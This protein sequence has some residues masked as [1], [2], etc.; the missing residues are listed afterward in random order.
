MEN[1][2]SYTIGKNANWR[3]HYRT[4]WRFLKNLKIELSYD[5]VIL[6]LGIYANKQ[7]QSIEE[8]PA[9]P[10][11]YHLLKITKI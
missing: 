11:N 1:E 10:F 2:N 4:V 8:I 3:S 6:L 9:L 7:K 5:P